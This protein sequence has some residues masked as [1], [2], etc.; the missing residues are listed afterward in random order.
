MIRCSICSNPLDEKYNVCPYCGKRQNEGMNTSG[1]NDNIT[2]ATPVQ[3]KHK[4][5][6]TTADAENLYIPSA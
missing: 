5:V 3:N 2:N 6:P 1:E 4:M